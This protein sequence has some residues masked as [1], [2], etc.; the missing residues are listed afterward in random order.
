[1]NTEGSNPKHPKCP[2]CLRQ[3]SMHCCTSCIHDIIAEKRIDQRQ[4]SMR[5]AAKRE[6][7]QDEFENWNNKKQK[8]LIIKN[9]TDLRSKKEELEIQLSAGKQSN[10]QIF[11]STYFPLGKKNPQN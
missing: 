4:I 10:F 2:T 1:M 9:I 6:G 8:S 7:L 5:I 3:R 11:A